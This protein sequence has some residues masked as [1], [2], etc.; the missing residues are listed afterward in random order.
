MKILLCLVVV[1]VVG[2]SEDSVGV[3]PIPTN[4][5]EKLQRDEDGYHYD[6]P[7]MTQE[8]IRQNYIK[9]TGKIPCI[10][11]DGTTYETGINK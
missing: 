4:Q 5:K 9:E 11:C 8:E 2:C 6:E 3:V 7:T 10:K 1:F